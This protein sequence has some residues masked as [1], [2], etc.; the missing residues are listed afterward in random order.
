MHV[1]TAGQRGPAKRRVV[2]TGIGA[3]T[4]LGHTMANTWSGI[5]E[6]VSVGAPVKR[7]D[8]SEFPTKIAY[9]VA[10]FKFRKDLVSAAEAELLN[11]A[12][13]YGVTAAAE[14]LEEAGL[15]A[16]KIDGERI[17]VC[18]G[19]G[20]CSPD[21]DWYE[22][23][24]LEKKFQ[25]PS[26]RRH[27]RFFPDQVSAVVARLAGAR[28][29]VTTIHTACASSG[30]SLGEAFEQ[31]AYGDV[32]VAVTG[33][34]DSMISPYYI[35]GF[36]LLGALSKRNDDPK[37]ASRPFDAGRDGFVLGEGACMLVFE[38]Y[39]HAKR[40]GAKILAEVRGYGITES[41]YRITDL[42]PE[43]HGPMEAM[44]MALDDAGIKASQVAYVNAH[45]T[46]TPL[47]DR[48]EGLAIS[49]VFNKET[50]DTL[51][52][53]TKSMTGHMISAAGAIEFAVC[54]KALEKQVLPPSVN[55]FEPDPECRVTLTASKPVDKRFD[56][57]LSN[58]V[59]FGGSNTA[60]VA[61]SVRQLRLETDSEGEVYARR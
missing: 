23:V 13:T 28:G 43:G 24:F 14:A 6:G 39:E 50:C 22:R 32:D 58:S 15:A 18:L 56:Y 3:V 61:G 37:T 26:L 46:S 34:T 27:L 52:S 47:N 4:P 44:Q 49:K 9:E 1:T 53:S 10:D 8:A 7:F 40:R 55:V 36:S 45:G 51:V 17:G 20:M 30:Q 29:G 2:V 57:V 59:G 35:A 38:E 41:A 54:I 31:V 42:H 60:L 21:F 25:D 11:E 48:L 12:G 33:G 16:A 19:V 5:V